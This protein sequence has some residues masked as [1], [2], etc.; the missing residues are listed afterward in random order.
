MAKISEGGQ[1]MTSNWEG[2]FCDTCQ[3]YHLR[4]LDDQH[5]PYAAV[6]IYPEDMIG[7]AHTLLMAAA[8]LGLVTVQSSEGEGHTIQ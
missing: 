8:E 1:E 7:L 5:E 2:Y 6:V 4:L 3:A